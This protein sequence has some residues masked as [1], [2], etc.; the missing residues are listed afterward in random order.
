MLPVASMSTT[1]GLAAHTPRLS[2]I[3]H[4]LGETL[5]KLTAR[6]FVNQRYRFTRSI[7][8]PELCDDWSDKTFELCTSGYGNFISDAI[9]SNKQPF[10]FLDIGANVGVFSL[11]ADRQTSCRKIQAFEPVPKTFHRLN[12]NVV[13][14]KARKISVHR[15]AISSEGSGLATMSFNQRHTGMAKLE[16]TGYPG[17]RVRTIGAD[18]LN[19]L[20]GGP[21]IPIMAKIDVEGAELQ[22][23]L[24]LSKTV[25]FHR[26]NTLIIEMSRRN[27]GANGIAELEIN[28]NSLGFRE[29]DRHGDAD[30]YDAVFEKQTG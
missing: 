7:Y 25:F 11:L 30:H 18:T 23:V 28:L 16:D 27:S 10:V 3:R 22:V 6:L 13:R 12:I 20:V 1:S 24:E 17:I 21:E 14:N 4:K 8:G 5:A 2:I 26:I 15:A 19:R 9:T 29:R